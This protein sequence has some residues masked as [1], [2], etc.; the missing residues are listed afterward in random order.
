MR[1]QNCGTTDRASGGESVSICIEC[2]IKFTCRL[3]ETCKGQTECHLNCAKCSNDPTRK[4]SAARK[5]QLIERFN[6]KIY[7]GPR[8]APPT[9]FSA[10]KNKDSSEDYSDVLLCH[11]RLYVLSDKYLIPELQKLAIH[12]LHATLKKFVLYPSRLRDIVMLVK[13]VFVNTKPKDEI[14]DMLSL[15]CAC[16]MKSLDDDEDGGLEMLVNEAPNFGW[17][18]IRT[19]G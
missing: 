12:R 2:R 14:C 13:Y 15:Y 17:A 11:A 10:R 6:S 18:L 19:L 1:C 3:C 16:I 9:E 5:Q 7:P 8:I 4:A